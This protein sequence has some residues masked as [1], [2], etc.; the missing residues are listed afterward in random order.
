[1]RIRVADQRNIIAHLQNG[2]AVRVRQNT[3]A[4]DTLDITTGLAINPQLAQIFTVG[5]GDQ[6][7]PDAIGANN[8][9]IDFTFGVG[10]QAALTSDL[11]GAGLKILML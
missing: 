2:I 9:Q 10:V 7:R 5:P 3:V 11:L 8:R 4:A 6:F 1:M